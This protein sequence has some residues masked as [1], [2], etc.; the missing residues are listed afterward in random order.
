MPRRGLGG[1]GRRGRGLVSGRARAQP[2]AER[3]GHGGPRSGPTGP[4]AFQRGQ[5][6]AELF[7]GPAAGSGFFQ[8]F[9]FSDRPDISLLLQIHSIIVCSRWRKF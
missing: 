7:A 3:A 5:R 1:R 9:R 4:V 2:G 8:E 6:G